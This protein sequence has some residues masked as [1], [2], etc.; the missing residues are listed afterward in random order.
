MGPKLLL[1]D[2][3]NTKHLVEP[4]SKLETD[5]G[6]FDIPAAVAPGTSVRSHLGAL[7]L[8]IRP[9][10]R[11]YVEK[12]RRVTSIP[13]YE[14]IGYVI[15]VSGLRDGHTVVE[16]GTGNGACALYFAQAVSPN[17]RVVSFEIRDDLHRVALDNVEGFGCRNIDLMNDDV[18]NRPESLRADLFFLDLAHPS[19]YIAVALASLVP[20]GSIAIYT[21]FVEEGSECV[22][23]LRDSGAMEIRMVEVPRREFEVLDAG[24]RPKT[25]QTVHSGYLVMGRSLPP[26]A[27]D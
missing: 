11:D 25:T 26:G 24:T 6:I 22:R 18:R 4:G 16:A 23:N 19:K 7:G 27:A 15:A 20:G 3:R 8:L 13:H 1:I 21:P 2:E 14:D 10:I 5:L 12:M 17:G 9:T